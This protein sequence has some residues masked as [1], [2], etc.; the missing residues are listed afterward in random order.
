MFWEENRDILP[1]TT[2]GGKLSPMVRSTLTNQGYATGNADQDSVVTGE[3]RVRAAPSC[4]DPQ[5]DES[6]AA[7]GKMNSNKKIRVVQW[8]LGAIARCIAQLKTTNEGLEHVR[9]MDD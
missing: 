6:T 1:G 2:S 7:G 9:H 3:S 4:D 8:G 5:Q